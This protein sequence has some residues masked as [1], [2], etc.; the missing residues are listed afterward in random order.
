MKP[1]AASAADDAVSARSPRPDAEGSASSGGSR[2]KVRQGPHRQGDFPGRAILEALLALGPATAPEITRA[3]DVKR[4]F[5][6]REIQDL[7]IRGLVTQ[8]QYPG[9]KTSVCYSLT[10]RSRALIEDIGDREQREF[11]RFASRY[12]A[13]EIEAFS[14][15]AETETRLLT[16]SRR[17]SPETLGKNGSGGG[18]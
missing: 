6:Q 17:K 11:T 7:H 18:T 10:P 3:L 16:H 5:V 1:S 9:H 12:S 4:Q 15:K 13:E 8:S 2:S 14:T